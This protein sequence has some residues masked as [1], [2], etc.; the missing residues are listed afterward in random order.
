[1]ALGPLA[2]WNPI[3]DSYWAASQFPVPS[4]CDVALHLALVFS[5]L[6]GGGI[7][8]TNEKR[9]CLHSVLVRP[10]MRRSSPGYQARRRR[11]MSD[12]GVV[13]F[14]SL[15]LISMVERIAER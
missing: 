12:M 8:T 11:S 13:D 9:T 1:L 7:D 15:P 3:F 6:D 10:A 5:D 2:G 4:V 14:S